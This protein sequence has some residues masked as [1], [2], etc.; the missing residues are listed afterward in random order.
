MVESSSASVLGSPAAEGSGGGGGVGSAVRRRLSRFPSD[1]RGL[2]DPERFPPIGVE[3][4]GSTVRDTPDEKNQ[5]VGRPAEPPLTQLSAS[6]VGLLSRSQ[7]GSRH[8]IRDMKVLRCE[9]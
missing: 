7:S 4:C 1:P 9:R 2:V 6:D 5:R 3:N 8:S